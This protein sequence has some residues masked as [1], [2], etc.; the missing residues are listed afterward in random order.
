MNLP[1][2]LELLLD[3]I[4]EVKKL[5]LLTGMEALVAH[6]VGYEDREHRMCAHFFELDDLQHEL[7]DRLHT[8]E[9]A[10]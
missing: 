8:I 7:E 10:L 3:K 4:E 6:M 9:D 2:K 5:K 1:H